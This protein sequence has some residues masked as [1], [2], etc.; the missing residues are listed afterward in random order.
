VALVRN[1]FL[2]LCFGA[3]VV[4]RLQLLVN[5][6]AAR[7][8][9]AVRAVHPAVGH[10]MRLV[11]LGIDVV[12]VLLDQPELVLNRRQLLLRHVLRAHHKQ[13]EVGQ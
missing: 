12:D 4:L 10:W 2:G 6:H 9:E 11:K 1:Y 3:R 8:A 7:H 5:I 13:V